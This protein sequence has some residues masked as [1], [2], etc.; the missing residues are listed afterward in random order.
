MTAPN[1]VAF[2]LFGIEVRWYGIFIALGMII[3]LLIGV[4]KLKKYGIPEDEGLNFFL[5]MVPAVIIGARLWY[6]IFE[7]SYY[8]LHPSEI[9]AVWHGGLAIQGGLIAGILTGYFFCRIRKISW[10]LFADA[11]FSGV[12]LAQA[13]GRWGNFFNQE[14]HGTET[15]L[16]WAITVFDPAKGSTIHVHPTFLYESLWNLALFGFL[17]LYDS[18]WK[19]CDGDIFFLYLIGYSIGRFFI[20]GLRTDS[21]MFLG[22]RMA[23]ITSILM[24]IAGIAGLIIVRRKSNS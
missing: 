9:F 7:W 2:R 17:W 8:R 12:P 20:E 16:P 11:A 5:V 18:K 1:P 24:I 19:K 23:Q 13:I 14:A 3:A 15:D 21:L 4:K 10:L 22:F 6:V